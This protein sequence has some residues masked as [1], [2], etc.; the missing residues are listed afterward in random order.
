MFFLIM[1]QS[2]S[3][4]YRTTSTMPLTYNNIYVRYYWRII[5]GVKPKENREF[6]L[7]F[8]LF[9]I[10]YRVD[11]KPKIKTIAFQSFHQEIKSTK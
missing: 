4:V 10:M 11:H 8:F 9:G 3:I 1:Y 6:G 7:I 2:N 5:F